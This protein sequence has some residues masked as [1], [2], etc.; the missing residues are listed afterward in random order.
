MCIQITVRSCQ[1]FRPLGPDHRASDSVGLR[2]GPRICI[3]NKLPSLAYAVG[4]RNLL[5]ETQ[6]SSYPMRPKQ[7]RIITFLI[8]ISLPLIFTFKLEIL[9]FE[10]NLER[11]LSPLLVCTWPGPRSGVCSSGKSWLIAVDP[12][13]S[14]LI[15]PIP[16]VPNWGS[17]P[18]QSWCRMPPLLPHH[19]H[20]Q[21]KVPEIGLL[22]RREKET[23]DIFS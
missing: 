5:W 22:P 3:S 2:W 21:L 6:T 17:P 23:F 13:V 7:R 14:G 8:Y 11:K 12:W 16:F 1:N 4:L 20:L 10:V 15:F 19:R 18:S 9:M